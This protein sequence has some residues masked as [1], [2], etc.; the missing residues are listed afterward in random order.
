LHFIYHLHI[1]FF[2]HFFIYIYNTSKQK[3][4]LAHLYFDL[5]HLTPLIRTTLPLPSCHQ[6]NLH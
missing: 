5:L 1:Y 6:M 2:Y 3:C 4:R